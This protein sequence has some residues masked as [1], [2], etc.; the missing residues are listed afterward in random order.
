MYQRRIA[1]TILTKRLASSRVLV[2]EG[3]KACG[4]T[5]LA[6]RV[7]RS[8]VLL[9][10]D[11]N[12]RRA[13]ALDPA[14][15]LEGKTP[16]LIDEW[17]VEP[18]IWNHLRRAVDA[19]GRPGQFILTGSAVPVDDITRHTGAG[20]I[21][22][23]RLRTMSLFESGH[24][25]AKV[26]LRALLAGRF[27]NCADS[28]L[29]FGEMVERLCIGGWPAHYKLPLKAAL[30]A[31]RDYLHEIQRSDIAR[32]DGVRR[33]PSMVA[34]ILRSLARNVAMPVTVRTIAADA[35]GTNGAL[36]DD[37]VRDCLSALCRLMI[38]EEQ[39]AWFTHL[40][41]RSVL[42]K[43]AKRHFADPSLA[44]AALGA[45]PD[46]LVGDLNLLG[47]LFESLV[48]RDL[49]VYADAADAQVYHYRD[50]TGLEVDAVV[51]DRSGAWCALEVK[52]GADQVDEAAATLLKFRERVNLKKRGAPGAIGVIVSTGYGYQRKDG[53]AVI[54]VGALCP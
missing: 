24:S 11:A 9:D 36:S 37:T 1:Q 14:L 43:S 22:R 28:G 17:Q 6:R 23:L 3:P 20:R 51:E 19:R 42:R 45:T 50:N 2:V 8:E 35:S 34:R 40:R 5:T 4:K 12:A 10:V 7:A 39:P 54:P 38:V 32:V 30:N 46:R 21:S 31:Q 48:F 52:L 33:D 16:R 29:D 27:A 44:V 53:V 25:S 18:A 47:L 41:S 15:V 49:S 26:S 13:V